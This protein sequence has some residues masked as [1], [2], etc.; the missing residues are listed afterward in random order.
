ME[1]ALA[2]K[3][4]CGSETKLGGYVIHV[5]KCV[6]LPS[7]PILK[8]GAIGF[9]LVSAL[10]LGRVQGISAK[11]HVMA[12]LMPA[13][14]RQMIGF[15]GWSG[16]ELLLILLIKR[17]Y[18]S[19]RLESLGSL[20]RGAAQSGRLELLIVHCVIGSFKLDSLQAAS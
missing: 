5:G 12:F 1:G 14:V 15:G 18:G 13:V 9:A 3:C 16:T 10:L 19:C 4:R 20:V 6:L 2:R 8:A 7:N 17:W 11:A